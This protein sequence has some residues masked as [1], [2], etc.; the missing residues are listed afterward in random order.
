MKN[1]VLALA[2][3]ALLATP[4]YGSLLM[5]EPFSYANGNLVPNGGWTNHSGSGSFIQVNAGVAQLAQGGGSREDANRGFGSATGTLYSAFDV[6]VDNGNL[7]VY[8]AHMMIGGSTT[9]RSRVWVI[10]DP[11]GAGDFTFAISDTSS[12]AVAWGSG[13]DFATTY[14]VVHSYD[15]ATGA[16]KL[17]VDQA[18]EAGTSVSAVVSTAVVA[19][20]AFALRQAAGDSTQAIDNA[21]VATS[22]NEAYNCIPEPGTALLL[23]L[24]IVGLIR[25]R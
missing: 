8:F 9:F 7:D 16:T 4:S 1:F 2:V 12:A 21:C 23:G 10:P 17:W 6:S 11:A 14:R 5:N 20:D 19:L 22:Y 18:T 25:R 3:V 13:L 15:L 24:G